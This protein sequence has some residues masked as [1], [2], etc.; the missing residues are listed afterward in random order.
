[1]TE[2]RYY[3]SIMLA[4]CAF[5]AGVPAVGFSGVANGRQW[6]IARVNTG[7]QL[8]RGH[9]EDTTLAEFKFSAQGIVMPSGTFFP[10]A[11]RLCFGDC[12]FVREAGVVAMRGL[13][14]SS[15]FAWVAVALLAGSSA[16]SY[17]QVYAGV[18]SPP[19]IAA[20]LLVVATI[21]A[22]MALGEFAHKVHALAQAHAHNFPGIDL[23]QVDIYGDGELGPDGWL[24]IECCF[25]AG[26]TAMLSSLAPY[27]GARLRREAVQSELL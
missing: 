6:A 10:F 26:V 11:S 23:S 3:M 14:T 16:A 25:T 19:Y 15:A 21:T 8:F 12:T 2:S 17:G 20:C 7:Q 13:D 27:I 24:F 4:G 5:L 1:M 9:D 18:Q 22:L